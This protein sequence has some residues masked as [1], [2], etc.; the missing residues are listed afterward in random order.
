MIDI[1]KGA[2]TSIRIRRREIEGYEFIDVR[3]WFVD[4]DGTLRPTSK[5]ISVPPD[6]ADELATSIRKV[7]RQAQTDDD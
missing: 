6:L 3:Q 1:Q 7:A 5:G 4:K 2:R